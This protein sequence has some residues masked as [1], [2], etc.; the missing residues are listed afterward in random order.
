MIPSMA[1]LLFFAVSLLF[2]GLGHLPDDPLQFFQIDDR[3]FWRIGL[4]L[5]RHHCYRRQELYC[6]EGLFHRLTPSM[7]G[8]IFLVRFDGDINLRAHL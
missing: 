2:L 4:G 3:C 1:A 6:V 5:A 7:F 8:G